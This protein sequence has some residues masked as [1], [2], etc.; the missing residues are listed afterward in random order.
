MSKAINET[1]RANAKAISVFDEEM[2]EL[3][4]ENVSAALSAVTKDRKMPFW[5]SVRGEDKAPGVL[6]NS[7]GD[8]DPSVGYIRTQSDSVFVAT[9]I[10]ISYGAVINSI[11]L[12]AEIYIPVTGNTFEMYGFRLY[13]ES[14][15]RW[16]SLTNNS[17]NGQDPSSVSLWLDSDWAL[18]QSGF[19]LVNEVVFPR[20]A[21]LRLE[22]FAQQSPLFYSA[23][24][25]YFSLS[26]YKV[27]G[28]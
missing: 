22:V 20:N 9:N 3:A 14:N 24:R 11:G 21:V 8:N 7:S 1:L 15:Y 28:G 5:Y 23:E 17:V 13:D 2:E 6:I 12:P 19:P 26:G 27:F 10:N 4:K 25:V 16:I 18:K